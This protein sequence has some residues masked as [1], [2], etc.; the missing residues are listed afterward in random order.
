VTVLGDLWCGIK[1]AF[2]STP[3]GAVI[4]PCA[5]GAL[6]PAQAQSWFDTF[7]ARTD[8]PWNYP[9]DC[10]YNR[11]HVMVQALQAAGVTAGKAITPQQWAALQ[12]RAGSTLVQTDATPY[13][14]DITGRVAPT[15]DAAEVTSIFDDHRAARA[16]NF[17]RAP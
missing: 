13:Y 12:G 15:P 4:T 5:A 8:I 6:T 2:A 1:S 10:C 9:D 7:K 14:R 3:A 11:A 16:A 17:P